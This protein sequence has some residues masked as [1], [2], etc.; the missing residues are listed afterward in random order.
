VAGATYLFGLFGEAAKKRGDWIDLAAPPVQG[1]IIQMNVDY[2]GIT[3][4][5]IAFLIMMLAMCVPILLMHY[6]S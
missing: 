2:S 4:S 3:V 1:Y 6:L 5:I